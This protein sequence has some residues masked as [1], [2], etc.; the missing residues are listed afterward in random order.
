[1]A[2]GVGGVDGVDGVAAERIGASEPS[3]E[4]CTPARPHVTP[5]ACMGAR[6]HEQECKLVTALRKK[7][8]ESDIVRNEYAN[9]PRFGILES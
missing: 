7:L 8:E 9:L 5:A 4:A 6:M 1:M 2:G 3:D